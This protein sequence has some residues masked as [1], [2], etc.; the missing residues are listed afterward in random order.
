MFGWRGFGYFIFLLFCLGRV[1]CGG[2]KEQKITVQKP[3]EPVAKPAE[4]VLIV[5]APVNFR[6][7][8][9]KEPYDLLTKS[10]I[11]VV[12]A[13]TDTIPAKGM[14]G[15]VVKP[16]ITLSRV[17]PDSFDALVIAGGTGCKVLWDNET[18]HKIVQTFNEKRKP[19]GAICIAPV[20]L[21][22]AGVLKDRKVTS[23][24]D[25]SHEIIPHCA[26]YTGADVEISD[27]IITASGPQAAK[28]FAKAIL[29]AVKK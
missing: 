3:E 11:D 14:L 21:A 18:L 6:D 27:N 9:F 26:G 25:V 13:S 15:M 28:D 19:I 16:Q 24:P 17:N 2:G 8:E 7:E 4:K 1:F 12:I 10:T 23:Y 22:R 29:E 5:I 20:V